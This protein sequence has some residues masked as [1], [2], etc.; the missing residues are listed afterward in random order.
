MAENREVIII[1]FFFRVEFSETMTAS[2]TEH[3][4]CRFDN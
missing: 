4:L 1:I 3:K 2:F